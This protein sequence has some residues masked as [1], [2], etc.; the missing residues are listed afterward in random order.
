MKNEKNKLQDISSIEK[1]IQCYT[2]IAWFFI[3]IGIIFAFIII[4]WPYLVPNY[5]LTFMEVGTYYSGILTGT[6]SLAGLL[7]V[8]VAYLGQR[9]SIVNQQEELKLTRYEMKST[10]DELEGQKNQMIQQN[11]NIEQQRFEDTFFNM[12]NLFNSIINDM[13]IGKDIVG[14][15][16]FNNIF[17]YISDTFKTNINYGPD[18][19]NIRVTINTSYKEVYDRY[20]Y[21]LDHYFRFLTHLIKFVKESTFYDKNKYIGVIKAQLSIKEQCILFYNIISDSGFIELKQLSIEKDL[22]DSLDENEL[23]DPS[24]KILL[25]TNS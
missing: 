12:M 11:K 4:I 5:K 14:R 25:I 1:R 24:H 19:N 7:F 21:I 20:N 9:I 23:M 15:Q 2:I 8:Y 16:C 17:R 22:L 3:I 18:K 6:F 10:R 13:K